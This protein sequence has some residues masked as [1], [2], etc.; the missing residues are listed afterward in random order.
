MS[1]FVKLRLVRGVFSAVALR[2]IPEKV[3]HPRPKGENCGGGG[4][5]VEGY[6][7]CAALLKVREPKL[8]P[9]KLP[10]NVS[11]PLQRRANVSV[12]KC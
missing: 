12:I 3:P 1:Y 9:G 5:K 8:S 7:Q 6:R 4:Y 2:S 10:F 11:I